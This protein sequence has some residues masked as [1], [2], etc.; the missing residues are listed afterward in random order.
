M[1]FGGDGTFLRAAELARYTDAALDGREPRPG[2]LPRRDRARGGRGDARRAIER[3][4]YSVE[5][6]LALAGRRPRRR[7]HGRRRHV[8]AQ[9]GVGREGRALAGARRRPRHRRPAADQLR[10]RRR[11]LRH[12][13]RLDR[14]RLLRR[15]AG[16]LAR[17][18]GAAARPEQ[19]P[20]A[21]RPAAGHLAGL[22]A[23]RRGARRRQPGAG[24]GRRAPHASRSPT[25]AGSTSAGPTGRCGSPGCTPRR[26]ATG[27]SPSSACRC[28]A[29]A[30]PG[31]MPDPGHELFTSRTV[32][33][34][35]IVTGDGQA[36]CAAGRGQ[37]R[38][39]LR[40]RADLRR[41]PRTADEPR[42]ASGD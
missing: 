6:R 33:G 5:E 34:R 2:R 10:L 15:R 13:H 8:G 40:R 41:R 22:G 30:T 4:E 24:L 27:W 29:S 16:G 26:S 35:D 20:R 25:A 18:R 28:A 12:A 23:H 21:V 14:L 31:T 42:E 11:P 1:V 37:R 39:A 19:R 32:L 7:R 17:R 9:R 3:C 36:P 38:H